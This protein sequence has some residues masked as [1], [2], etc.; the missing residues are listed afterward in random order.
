[1][2]M[3]VQTHE[4]GLLAV[5]EGQWVCCE[6]EP[7]QIDYRALAMLPASKITQLAAL[8]LVPSCSCA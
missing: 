7:G 2:R 8:V 4:L 6:I 5:E 1:M 3:S